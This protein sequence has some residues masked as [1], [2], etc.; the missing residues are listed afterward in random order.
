LS[1]TSKKSNK[2]LKKVK[3]EKKSLIVQLCESHV[4]IDS[5]KSKNTMLLNTIDALENKLE[6]F[7]S[8]N[9]K[10]MLCIHSNISN[11]PTLIVDD[12]STSTS[13]ASDSELDSIDIKLVI[14]D[15]T[16]LENSCLNNHVMPKFKESE[17][18]GKFVPTCHNCGKISHIRPNYY[19]LKSHRPWIKQ[20]APKKGKVENSFSSK[21]VPPHMRRIKGKGNIICKN[22]NI[23]ST[24]IV[25]KHSNKRS[26]PTCHHCGV[27]GHIWPKCPHLQAQ[28]SKVQRELPARVI[29]GT[30]PP[31][32]HQAPLHQ[33]QFVPANQSGK[34]NKNKSR[35]YKRKPQKPNSNHSYEGLLSLMQGMLKRMAN[36]D[37]TCK[38]PPRVK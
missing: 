34:P 3:Q 2:E 32:A 24:E 31:M 27:T 12:M 14:V 36:M 20:D 30:L 19:L 25:K 26:M 18:W 9:L 17:T 8:D 16:C 22:A 4:L 1:K 13:H 11:K 35:R 15:T 5:L 38:P 23:K 21:Y 28:K 7:S 37:K 33:Q 10:S 29:S 6:K